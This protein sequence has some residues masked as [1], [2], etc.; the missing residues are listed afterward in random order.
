[1]EP[2]GIYSANSEV[3]LGLALGATSASAMRI[4]PA[5]TLKGS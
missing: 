1:M 3:G 4:E 2:A 5:L